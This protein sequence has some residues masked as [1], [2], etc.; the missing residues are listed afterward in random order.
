MEKYISTETATPIIKRKLIIFPT[1]RYLSIKKERAET[2]IS[3][4]LLVFA[5]IIDEVKNRAI[6][7]RMKKRKITPE[8]PGVVKY[9]RKEIAPHKKTILI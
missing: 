8:L 3:K 1:P 4:P 5:S 7:K 2:A 6:K 9:M